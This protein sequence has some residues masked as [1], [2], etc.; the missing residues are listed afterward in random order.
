[1]DTQKQILRKIVKELRSPDFGYTEDGGNGE[2]LSKNGHLIIRDG[3]FYGGDD[4]L[5]QMKR[6]WQMD[7]YDGY[8]AEKYGAQFEIIESRSIV[9]GGTMYG[10]KQTDGVNEIV[11]KVTL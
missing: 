4:K 6:E 8:F 11:L 1:M 3:W 7:V 9:R 5:A 2:A 10:R